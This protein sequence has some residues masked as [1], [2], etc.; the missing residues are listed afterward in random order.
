MTKSYKQSRWSLNDMFSAPDGPEMDAA[1]VEIEKGAA[2]IEARRPQLTEAITSSEFLDF[3]HELEKLERKAYRI[4][5]YAAALFSEDTQNP[6]ALT[7]MG[8]SDQFLTEMGNRLLFFS[9]WWKGLS[10]EK[11]AQLMKDSGDYHYFLE[12]MRH[13][14]PHTLSEPEEKII[15]LKNITGSS[16]LSTLYS[17]FTNRYQFPLK[18]GR[19]SLMLTRGE[20]M[21]YV[22]QS[23]PDLRAKAYQSLYKV[24]GDDGPI[25]GQMYQTRVRDWQIEQVTLR[26]FASPIAARNLGN[27]IPD[28]V[29][30]TLLDVAQK[31]NQVFQRFFQL[32]A[33]WLGLQR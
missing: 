8:R 23:D 20:L 14:K 15:N 6:A 13:F 22:R 33:R 27:D 11:A 26:K 21:M 29:V 4:G 10:D 12:E 19:K 3:L 32:K 1:F 18:V 30:D 24:Y 7:L 2:A 9:L 31:N 5:A 16:A 25:L 17:T 28:Q